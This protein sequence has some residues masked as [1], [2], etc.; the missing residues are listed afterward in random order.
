MSLLLLKTVK[1]VKSNIERE[2]NQRLLNQF[3]KCQILNKIQE[4]AN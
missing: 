4:I 2:N 3:W 1:I